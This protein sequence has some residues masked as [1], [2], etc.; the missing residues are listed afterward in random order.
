MT[1]KELYNGPEI[2]YRTHEIKRQDH[3]RQEQQ[4]IARYQ[5]PHGPTALLVILFDFLLRI[6]PR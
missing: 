4:K 1:T 2:T 5:L 6:D 3:K